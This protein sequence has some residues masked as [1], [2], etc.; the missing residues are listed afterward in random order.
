[1]SNII[2]QEYEGRDC[3]ITINPWGSDLSVF[4]AIMSMIYNPTREIYLNNIETARRETWKHIPAIKSH[5][6]EEITLDK[7]VQRL[8]TRVLCESWQ[9]RRTSLTNA[10]VKMGDRVPSFFTSRSLVNMGGL[11]IHDQYHQNGNGHHNIMYHNT[12]HQNGEPATNRQVK[13]KPTI[14][15]DF[16]PGW[17]GMGLKGNHSKHSLNSL[18]GQ[19]KPKSA[20]D[21]GLR[22]GWGGMGLK[23]NHSRHSLNS[24]CSVTS[25]LFYEGDEEEDEEQTNHTENGTDTNGMQMEYLKT[26]SMAEFYYKRSKSTSQNSLQHFPVPVHPP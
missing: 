21:I 7:C 18:T 17:G 1:M 25:G 12:T 8:R 14:D 10:Q 22:P 15:T 11:A 23:G 24:L 9:E 20:H 2:T 3:D 16:R 4:R 6:A 26:T 5:I 13:H 19:A